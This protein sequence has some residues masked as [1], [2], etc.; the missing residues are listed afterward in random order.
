MRRTSTSDPRRLEADLLAELSAVY[1][2]TEEI[3]HG[4]SCQASTECCRFGITGREPYVTSIELAAVRRAIAAR[5]GPRALQGIVRADGGSAA[6]DPQAKVDGGAGRRRVLPNAAERRCPMLTDAGR[7][8]IYAARPLGCRTFYCDRASA[9]APVRH[10]DVTRL[11]RKVQEVA[12]RHEPGGDLGRPL[13]RALADDVAG[14][15][16]APSRSGGAR[17]GR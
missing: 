6:P 5:G 17:R 13:T 1:R 10:H 9:G 7:C 3:F 15:A 16:G 11:V 14:A 8:A 12:A 2:E 4:W